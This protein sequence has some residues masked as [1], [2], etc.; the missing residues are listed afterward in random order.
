MQFHFVHDGL[1]A[2]PEACKHGAAV[3][4]AAVKAAPDSGWSSVESERLQELRG[5]QIMGPR[6]GSDAARS[7]VY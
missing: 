1:E 2:A 5:Q 7:R 4:A 6:R 3:S